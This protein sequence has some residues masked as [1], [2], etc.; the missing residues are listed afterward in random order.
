MISI[1]TENPN[2][3]MELILPNKMVLLRAKNNNSV[4]FR[5]REKSYV[6]GFRTKELAT[7][8]IKHVAYDSQIS[9]RD[10]SF[11]N[12]KTDMER[13]DPNMTTVPITKLMMDTDAKLV[14]EKKQRA[15]K[16]VT[17]MTPS[18]EFLMYPITKNIGVVIV[19]SLVN[20][21]KEHLVYNM[22][23]I[24]PSFTPQMFEL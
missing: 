6:I 11:M 4:G 21:T 20:E 18:D 16:L 23:V 5:S 12:I 14:I 8:A 1:H 24:A 3:M 2:F 22:H 15:G 17:V 19:N 10:V 13:L 7:T 9:M